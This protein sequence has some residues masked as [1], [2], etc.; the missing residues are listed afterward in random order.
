MQMNLPVAAVVSQPWSAWKHSH[1]PGQQLVLHA[2]VHTDDEETKKQS[3]TT[4]C[5]IQ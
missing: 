2:V 1:E 3:N 4:T 5:E